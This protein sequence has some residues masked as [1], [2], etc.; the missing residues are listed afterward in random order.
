[1]PVIP[2]EQESLKSFGKSQHTY[3]QKGRDYGVL[4]W[5]VFKNKKPR[6]AEDFQKIHPVYDLLMLQEAKVNFQT[7]NF[8]VYDLEYA[9]HFGESFALNKCGSSCGVLTGSQIQEA[10]AINKHGP[11][12]EPFLRTPKSTIFTYYPIKDMGEELLVINTHFV[13]FRSSKAFEKQL[14]QVMEMITVHSGP[15]IFAGDFNTWSKKRMTFLDHHMLDAGLNMVQFTNESRRFLLLDHIFTRGM[16]IK[17]A[18][19]LHD[20]KSSDHL[21][22]SFWFSFRA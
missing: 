22:L 19:L 11:I 20:I 4:S 12:R 21:P 17:N 10:Q 6:W 7:Q 14:N 13:N 5:N 1:M 16:D 2:H 18:H 3:F 15:L 8:E 9:W